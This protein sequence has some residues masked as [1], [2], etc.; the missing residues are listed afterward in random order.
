MISFRA[1]LLCIFIPLLLLTLG[2][3]TWSVFSATKNAGQAFANNELD[4]AERVFD[5]LIREDRTQLKN[6]VTILAED[7]GFRQAVATGERDTQ[8]SALA[9]H[10]E[11]IG[12]EIVL[13]TNAAGEVLLSSHDLQEAQ[14]TI[15]R[16]VQQGASFDM[17]LEVE[18]KPYQ[19]AV[20]PVYA[21]NLLGWVGLGFPLDEA[22]LKKFKSISRVD[23][24]I[25]VGREVLP[26]L[27]TL[28]PGHDLLENK[29]ADNFGRAENWL[30]RTV[31]LSG[32]GGDE[33][34]ALLTVSASDIKAQFNQLQ[35]RLVI[36]AAVTLILIILAVFSIANGLSRP[37]SV[38]AAAADRMAAGDYGREISFSRAD[39]IG[40]LASSLNSMQAAIKD[41]EAHI[42]YV[43]EHDERTG[44]PNREKAQ[45]IL[46]ELFDEGTSFTG[47]LL[48]VTNIKRLND[49]YGI[50]FV[51]RFVPLMAERM[52][53]EVTACGTLARL[54]S[55]EFLLI[56]TAGSVINRQEITALAE[57]FKHPFSLDGVQI[58][59]EAA[60]GVI[61][62]PEQAANY[63]ELIRRSNIALAESV[64][65]GKNFYD[66]QA[67]ADESHLRKLNITARLQQ[68][69]ANHGF[70]LFYQ[71]QQS[72]LDDSIEGL[73]ALIRWEDEVL[74]KVFPDEF[75]PL[76]EESGLIS[77][78]TR[79]VLA[80]VQQDLK[81]IGEAGGAIE[82]SINLSA[83]DILDTDMLDTLTRAAT[84]TMP[85]GCSLAYEITETA[86]VTDAHSARE[87]LLVLQR[88]GIRLS[89]D[90]FGTG[91]SSL[92]QLKMLPVSKLKI[93][94]SFV[95]ELA[96]DQDDQKIVE[97][98]LGLARALN[99][100]VIAEGV[101]DEQAKALLRRWGCQS[102]Q[103]YYLARPMT[104]AATLKWLTEYNSASMES[105]THS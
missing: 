32:A 95:L 24:T 4:V 57:C 41:R 56:M 101:E 51:Q 44:L 74:G 62:C 65:A 72:L 42:T 70:E 16:D 37:L 14:S 60:A 12:A 21:P 17:L 63:E 5:Q 80:Q 59:F 34:S 85:A 99:L 40:Q 7:Y 50:L 33:L 31:W 96:K 19:F 103:G 67:G 73:E 23:V 1:R 91:F 2:A 22:L 68:A 71:P 83:K 35:R 61:E 9:N 75:I 98:T 53:N 93:D 38:L 86:L 82:V 28:A 18:H 6:S 11:R 88:A 29:A 20:V 78:I 90:D 55:D 87:N 102:I 66:Y 36:I 54:G 58:V 84:Q 13:L 47:V 89:M 100:S 79:W 27:T 92:S 77:D 97:A 15:V 10:G 49:L 8:I 48:R 30:S 64:R 76:A 43:A 45:Q 105:R 52:R 46:N 3:I 81:H 104:L 26:N 39:E 25:M 69:I 94:K